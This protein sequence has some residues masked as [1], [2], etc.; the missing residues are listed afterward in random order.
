MSSWFDTSSARRRAAR[1][2]V[3]PN[4]CDRGDMQIKKMTILVKEDADLI[5]MTVVFASMSGLM[6]RSY[7]VR[8]GNGW[9]PFVAAITFLLSALVC[10]YLLYAT[11]VSRE[12]KKCGGVAFRV[13]LVSER[14]GKT[15]VLKCSA[16]GQLQRSR[17]QP[18]GRSADPDARRTTMSQLWDASRRNERDVE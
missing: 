3:L 17:V 9:I 5:G 18:T 15:R 16:C 7:I 11:A 4:I 1:G 6:L 13:P 8:A 2:H 14:A 10:G 12:C